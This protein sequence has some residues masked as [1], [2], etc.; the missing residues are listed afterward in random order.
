M[1]NL[2]ITQM[3]KEEL[4]QATLDVL[5]ENVGLFEAMIESNEEVLVKKQFSDSLPPDKRC[6][7]DILKGVTA[8]FENQIQMIADTKTTL[9]GISKF[10]D[11]DPAI[12]LG[13][14]LIKIE[15]SVTAQFNTF[16]GVT[17]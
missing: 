8:N 6:S 2:D 15:R 14:K 17:S 12:D 10:C 4:V 1:K 9:A 3:S 5:S 13:C 16:Q 11:S 7:E